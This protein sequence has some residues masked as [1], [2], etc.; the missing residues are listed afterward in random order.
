MRRARPLGHVACLLLREAAHTLSSKSSGLQNISACKPYLVPRA[1]RCPQS[2]RETWDG[3]RRTSR[4]QPPHTLVRPCMHPGSALR[5]QVVCRVCGR[6]MLCNAVGRRAGSWH[7]NAQLRMA[8][9]YHL[10]D[11]HGRL[12]ARSPQNDMLLV[13]S[14]SEVRP[15]LLMGLSSQFEL[16]SRRR[17]VLT[18]REGSHD[19]RPF[20]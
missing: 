5:K 19:S 4:P 16:L 14:C 10:Y 3:L 7:P 17:G 18:R 20:L 15:K 9:P 11:L 1:H 2:T 12:D 13:I 8:Q 6:S